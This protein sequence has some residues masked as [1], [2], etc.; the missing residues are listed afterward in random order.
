MACPSPLR[1]YHEQLE[2]AWIPYGTRCEVVGQYASVEIEYA[3]IRKAAGALDCPHRSLLRVSGAD[4]LDFLHRILSNECLS[5]QPGQVRRSFML[6]AKGRIMA[7]LLL[8]GGDGHTLV[9]LDIHQAQDVA[10]ELQ[11]M[12]FS[13]DVVIEN[14]D[15][16]KHRLSF[17]GPLAEAVIDDLLATAW[18][19]AAPDRFRYDETGEAG[20]HVWL[21]P[22]AAERIADR[23][24]HLR[25]TFRFKPIGWLAYNI[26]RVEAG[27]PLF[28]IDFGPDTLPHETGPTILAEAVSLSKGCYRGQEIV[29]R[30]DSRGRQAKVLVGFRGEDMAVPVAG[31]PVTDDATAEAETVGAVTSSTYSPLY[32]QAAVGLAM[33]K[34]SHHEP[35]TRL[36]SPADGRR[37][38]ITVN[39][40][41]ASE[42]SNP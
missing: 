3:A 23:E 13:E 21:E 14:Q 4:H 12:V 8:L 18:Q 1:A 40:L 22:D 33:V 39:P 35:G 17:H 2:A 15:E 34:W 37:V 6:D 11:K 36:F 19:G 27:H 42:A 16:V 31:S 24:Q 30:M 38:P 25:E 41:G 9:D 20:W 10:G 7:D 28:N 32:A 26:A 29:A 5:L